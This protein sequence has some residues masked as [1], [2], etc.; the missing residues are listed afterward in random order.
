M[1]LV[2]T[3]QNREEG[4]HHNLFYTIRQLQTPAQNRCHQMHLL[5]ERL[6]FAYFL[7]SFLQVMIW[8]FEGRSQ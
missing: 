5:A 6:F 7:A 4:Q 8:F 2:S 3:L 1:K